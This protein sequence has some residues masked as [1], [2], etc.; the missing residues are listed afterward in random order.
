MPTVN[1]LKQPGVKDRIIHA[2]TS[3]AR[4]FQDQF[5]S[6]MRVALLGESKLDV[7][8]WEE[9]CYNGLLDMSEYL[10]NQRGLIPW[11]MK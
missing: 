9:P 3:L 8:N 11:N 2:W 6:E 1:I 10:V 7:K 4:Q 5:F